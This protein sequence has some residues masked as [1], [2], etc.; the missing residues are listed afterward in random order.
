[1]SRE[2]HGASSI[3]G[4]GKCARYLFR[5]GHGH[6]LIGVCFLV[7]IGCMPGCISN[8]KKLAL[9]E[10][11][12]PE[13]VLVC[14]YELETGV[15]MQVRGL[16]WEEKGVALRIQEKLLFPKG[17]LPSE[18]QESDFEVRSAWEYT[19]RTQGDRL[20][21]ET[22]DGPVILLD[23]SGEQ[24]SIPIL[25]VVNPGEAAQDLEQEQGRCRI[26]GR[27]DREYFGRPR[28]LVTVSCQVPAPSPEHGP[29]AL[30]YVLATGL[31]MV[32]RQWQGL[33]S[34]LELRAVHQQGLP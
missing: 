6:L 34:T 33:D 13:P 4:L 8:A 21:K 32:S 7:L 19:L 1:M 2:T 28:T 14:E 16:Q 27:E 5:P 22:R 30:E 23:V 9:K 24:W 31:G 11:L 20:I 25:R 29:Q 3:L 15:G 26:T 17:L 10:F 12:G 18:L